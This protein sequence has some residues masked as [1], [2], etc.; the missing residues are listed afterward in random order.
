MYQ[1]R[2]ELDI[3]ALYLG[4]YT[5]QFYLREI[6][7]KAKMP[8]KTTQ[9]MLASLE[10]NAILRSRI[11]GKNKYFSLNLDNIRAKSAILQAEI[12]Q[13]TR[14]LE[15]YAPIKTFLKSIK[16]NEMIVVFGS[17][18]KFSADNDSDLDLLIITEGK[19]DIPLHLMPYTAHKTELS[20]KSFLDAVEKGETLIKEIEDNHIILNNHS[21]YVN[22]MWNH[23]GKR[24]D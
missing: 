10:K 3:I 18:A 4:D 12:Q 24:Q 5:R 19:Q 16:T 15:R 17:F 8:L 11:S 14:F 1:K 2:N 22:T 20:E 9:N 21:F 13:T 6:S 7:K 23:Y